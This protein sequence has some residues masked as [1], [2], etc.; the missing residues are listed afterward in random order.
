MSSKNIIIDSIHTLYKDNIISYKI[1]LYV[2]NLNSL[3]NLLNDLNK[4]RYV[5]ESRRL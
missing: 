1:S 2:N 5:K 3:N 4:I